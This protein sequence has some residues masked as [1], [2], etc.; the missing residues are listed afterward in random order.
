MRLVALPTIVLDRSTFTGSIIM[1]RL[2]GQITLITG[3]ASGLGKGIAQR[4]TEEG[5]TVYITDIQ[6]EQG[7]EVADVLG[8]TFLQQNVAKEDEWISTLAHV[9][10]AHGRLD[11]LVNNAGIVNS[12]PVD[13]MPLEEWQRVIDVNLTG[14]FLGCKHGVAA[15]KNNPDSAGGSI[16]NLSSVTGLRANWWCGL[17]SQ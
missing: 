11:T 8:A 7:Q 3:G 6:A 13:Q 4:F 9:T 5:A 2:E 16:I 15:L 10:E 17:F 12:C 14:V 1:G